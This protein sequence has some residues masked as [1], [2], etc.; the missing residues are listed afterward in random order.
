MSEGD[1][2]NDDMS[3]KKNTQHYNQLNILPTSMKTLAMLPLKKL[4]LLKSVPTTKGR[5]SPEKM[6]SIGLLKGEVYQKRKQMLPE[7]K[8][9]FAALLKLPDKEVQK[10]LLDVINNHKP[11]ECRNVETQTDFTEHISPKS[12]KDEEILI[13]NTASADSANSGVYKTSNGGKAAND[14]EA[15]PTDVPKK[16]KRKR[17]VSLPQA[18]KE[19][20]AKQVVKMNRPKTIPTNDNNLPRSQFSEATNGMKRQRMEST[21]SECSSDVANICDDFVTNPSR[22]IEK[23][24]ICL[25]NGLLYVFYVIIFS[26]F[27]NIKPIFCLFRPIQ[28]AVVRNQISKLQVHV[29]IWKLLNWDLNDLV[30]DEDEVKTFFAIANLDNFRR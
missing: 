1:F 24:N 25:E 16:R 3:I 12:I 15:T 11:V 26:K 17:K 2:K 30:T 9:L 7:Y 18:N 28:D 21:F 10:K 29:K 23:W 8:E 27:R 19:S 5:L 13:S 22:E 6:S 4:T 14:V 20:R